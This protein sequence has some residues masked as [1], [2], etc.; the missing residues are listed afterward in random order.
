MSNAGRKIPRLE[1]DVTLTKPQSVERIRF[2]LRASRGL[3]PLDWRRYLTTCWLSIDECS[4]TC[5]LTVMD[6]TVAPAS[7]SRHLNSVAPP[8]RLFHSIY[9][10]NSSI[11]CLAA[12]ESYIFGGRQSGDIL[13]L[14]IHRY[15]ISLGSKPSLRRFG[16]VIYIRKKQL[17]KVMRGAY[18]P[19]SMQP[20]RNGFSVHQ[21]CRS[22]ALSTSIIC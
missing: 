12:T 17:S 10:P 14:Y 20:P 4:R 22:V 8:P 21:V 2:D 18:L 9:Q 15:T 13:V 16:T 11:L 6:F 3:L 5:H 7:L 19:W 1:R